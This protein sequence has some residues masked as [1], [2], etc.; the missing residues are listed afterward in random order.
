M[1]T[2]IE[3]FLRYFDAVNRRALRDVAAL[4]EVADGWTPA[5][6]EGEGAWS[7]NQLIGHM[8]GSR[9]YFASAYRG[10][11]WITP[12]HFDTSS[13]ERWLPALKES[14]VALVEA[15]AGTP[16][17]WLNRKVEMIDS[18]GGLSGWRILMM[19]LEH[20]QTGELLAALRQTTDGYAAPDD[21]CASYRSLYERLAALEADTHV[22]IHLENNVLFP[23]VGSGA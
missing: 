23:A 15:L 12:R 4:P 10:E 17:E 7:I 14:G 8:A 9:L 3:S 13:R 20:D 1:I 5:T 2:S 6:G 16:D 21:A 22:H 11:G 19:M 18:D